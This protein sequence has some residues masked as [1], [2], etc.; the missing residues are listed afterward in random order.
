MHRY[1]ILLMLVVGMIAAPFEPS[2]AA[3]NRDTD[4]AIIGSPTLLK[5]ST[6]KIIL[7]DNM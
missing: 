3:T 1:I 7:F 4:H 5:D 2:H 6:F